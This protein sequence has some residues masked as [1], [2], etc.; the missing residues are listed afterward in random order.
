MG[1]GMWISTLLAVD[2]LELAL[3][4]EMRQCPKGAE[5]ESE[6]SSHPAT[7]SPRAHKPLSLAC[8]IPPA[9]PLPSEVLSSTLERSLPACL[10]SLWGFPSFSAVLAS[11]DNVCITQTGL[12][13]M[14]SLV[15]EVRHLD[16][17][18]QPASTV[19]A[20]RAWAVC[21][22]CVPGPLSASSQGNNM[23]DSHRLS[24]GKGHK[25]PSVPPVL[26]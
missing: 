3:G 5:G 11:G 25:S 22:A 13:W 4:L 18:P 15:A 6:P 17:Q 23:D 8:G 19:A 2:R 9:Y 26:H 24:P 7:C 12:G 16:T 21:P 1:T 10:L 14:R 20:P